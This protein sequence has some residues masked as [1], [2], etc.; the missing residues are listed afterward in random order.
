MFL[1]RSPSL[2]KPPCFSDRV[3]HHDLHPGHSPCVPPEA[4]ASLF[5]PCSLPPGVWLQ[6]SSNMPLP[7]GRHSTGRR[8][9]A[10]GGWGIQPS[11]FFS[12]KPDCGRDCV[13]LPKTTSP[14]SRALSGSS[15]HIPVILLSAGPCWPRGAKDI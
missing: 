8:D 5:H 7:F 1:K 13:P 4:H 9:G 3:S 14:V 15:P 11:V 6:K 10:E 12:A 2:Y